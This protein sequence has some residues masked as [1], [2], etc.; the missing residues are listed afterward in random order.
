[1]KC[2]LCGSTAVVAR[3]VIPDFVEKTQ[4]GLDPYDLIYEAGGQAECRICGRVFPADQ[5][6][7][8]DSRGSQGNR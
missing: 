5:S 7:P 3:T 8:S 6:D 1:M 2:P 4:Q